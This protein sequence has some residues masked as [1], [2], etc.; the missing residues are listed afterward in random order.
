MVAA[1]IPSP[2]AEGSNASANIAAIQ[3]IGR[4]ARNPQKQSKQ[5]TSLQPD[6]Q[7]CKLYQDEYI[8]QE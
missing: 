6:V 2:S 8:S 3:K 4:H 7:L 1:Q 5:K